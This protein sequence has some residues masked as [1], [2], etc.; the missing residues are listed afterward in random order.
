[1][2]ILEVSGYAF[3]LRIFKESEIAQ[4][5]IEIIRFYEQYLK[6]ATKEAFG[7]KRLGKYNL[8]MIK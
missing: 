2:S 5:I 4:E 3:I 8:R 7:T 6:K 1:M